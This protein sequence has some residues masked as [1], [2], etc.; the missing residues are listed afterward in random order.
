[1]SPRSRTPLPLG[2]PYRAIRRIL[3]GVWYYARGVTQKMTDVDIL[4]LASGIAFNALL[5]VIPLMLL[6]ASAIG[7]FLNSSSLG[8]QHLHEV[9]DAVFPQQPFAQEIR[10]SIIGIVA[11]IVV[12]RTSLGVFGI[13]VLVW[14]T[15]SLF[16]AIRSALHRVYAIGRKRGL[17]ISLIHD[18][19]LLLLAFICF[20]SVNLSLWISD[21]V[22]GLIK[23][24]PELSRISLA[25][26]RSY[27]PSVV[28][29]LITGLMFYILYRHMTDDK[30]PAPAA[31]IS[32]LTATLL[33]LVAGR[34]FAVYL[35]ELS[36]VA[37]LYGTYAFF[38]VFLV[39]IY[40]SSLIFVFGAIVG[41]VYWQRVRRIRPGPSVGLASRPP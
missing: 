11:D 39:W 14:T 26:I 10:T 13:V 21:L 5:S 18:L 34:V 33:W 7:I 28:V 19:G 1:V 37:A 31:L 29:V 30:P 4:F 35:T 38:A 32:T 24:T 20:L 41:Q 40:Y 12:Y 27:L 16:D 22:D 8:V 15:L 17:I 25:P 6:V 3:R 36:N 9:L 2:R 23:S